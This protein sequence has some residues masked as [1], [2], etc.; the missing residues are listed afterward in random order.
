MTDNIVMEK[1][2]QDDQFAE[3]QV[4]CSSPKV[5]ATT[6]IYLDLPLIE[7]LIRQ[8][9]S[10]IQNPQ[11][12]T[13]WESDEKEND[14]TT[15]LSL[16]FIQKDIWAHPVIEVFAKIDDG[17]SCADHHC[18]FYV[19]T[20]IGLLIGFQKKLKRLFEGDLFSPIQLNDT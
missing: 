2:W 5:T 10:F 4:R 11:E 14:P 17:A 9:D 12:P 6:Q 19:E 3:F 16:K 18:C 8:I 1:I 7:E 13:L 20:E 15:Y